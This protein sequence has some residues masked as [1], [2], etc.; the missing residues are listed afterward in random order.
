MGRIL[1]KR[2][3]RCMAC[4]TKTPEPNLLT[5]PSPFDA[6]NTLTGCPECRQCDEGFELLCDEPGCDSRANCGW[7]TGN[8]G[9]AW[10]GY[11]NTCG[12]H[13]TAN[14]EV[15]GRPLADGRA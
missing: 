5:A 9:D 2:R 6:D 11:R 3:W 8:D 15:S 4:G 1:E 12:K 10:G 14:A 13:M 7:P